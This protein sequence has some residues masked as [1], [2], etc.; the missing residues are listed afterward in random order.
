MLREIRNYLHQ[1]AYRKSLSDLSMEIFHHELE[2]WYKEGFFQE[3]YIPYSIIDGEKI[4]ANVSITLMDLIIAGEKK[5]AIQIGTVMTDKKYRRQGLIKRLMKVIIEEYENE[6]DYFYLFANDKALRLYPKFGFKRV[7]ESQ[8]M[9]NPLGINRKEAEIT[10]LDPNHPTDRQLL[11]Q[12][13]KSRVP[14]SKK[15]GV[16]NDE[17][18][19]VTSTL[20]PKCTYLHRYY[21]AC[22]NVLILASREENELSIYDI[23]SSQPYSLDR[24]IEKMVQAKDRNI[25]F[26]FV[27]ELEKYRVRKTKADWQDET[28]FIRTKQ[29]L[30]NELLFPLTS[31]I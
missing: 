9:L 16:L 30:P 8:Y 31:H 17:W 13:T 4:V 29:Q 22:E 5:K 6:V 2:P 3:K 15:M 24:V 10:L 28:L 14:V 19:L 11:E 12:M 26:H 21:L 18:P 20:D 1:S 25:V 23:I 27:P 7:D